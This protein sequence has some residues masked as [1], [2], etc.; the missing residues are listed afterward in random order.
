MAKRILETTIK[1]KI[2]SG[3]ILACYS[4]TSTFSPILSSVAAFI[5]IMF[6]IYQLTFTKTEGP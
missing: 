4:S 1:K 3:D 6:F 5:L 2:L